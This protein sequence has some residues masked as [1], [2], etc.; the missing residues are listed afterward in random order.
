VCSLCTARFPATL[1]TR[2]K[3][4]IYGRR[5][6]G[7]RKDLTAAEG[8]IKDLL[9][10]RDENGGERW[11]P[12]Y[13][14]ILLNVPL[15]VKLDLVYP[16]YANAAKLFFTIKA[17][18]DGNR[19][20][21]KEAV[22]QACQQGIAA[23]PSMVDNAADAVE[24]A[25]PFVQSAISFADTWGPVLKKLEALQSIGTHLSEVTPFSTFRV[26]DVAK[27]RYL[28]SS[29]RQ[30]GLVHFEFHTNGEFISFEITCR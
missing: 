18:S 30:N 4:E 13:A 10:A 7:H 1:A 19:E 3:F 24:T 16:N 11:R 22:A 2:I 8:T 27:L 20:D 29:I 6:V 5:I 14:T 9:D 21:M 15:V 12:N 23:L 26:L 28:D 17:V 25:N